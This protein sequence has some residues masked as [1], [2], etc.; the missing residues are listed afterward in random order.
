[1]LQSHNMP[2]NTI[3]PLCVHTYVHVEAQSVRGVSG[4]YLLV[5]RTQ[6]GQTWQWHRSL[7]LPWVASA[8]VTAKE[9]S[10]AGQM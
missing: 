2:H 6:D 10:Y 5:T 9:A 1:M 8:L 3:H 7:P 4:A